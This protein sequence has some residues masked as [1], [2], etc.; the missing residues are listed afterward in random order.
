MNVSVP[1]IKLACDSGP[2]SDATWLFEHRG[3]PRAER[4][5]LRLPTA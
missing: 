3:A 1:V 4:E 2:A 5:G